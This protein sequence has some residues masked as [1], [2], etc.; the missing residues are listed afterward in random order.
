ML[1]Y[2]HRISKSW[3][4]RGCSQT[5]SGV[6][7]AILVVGQFPTREDR[8]LFVSLHVAGMFS[9]R[10]GLACSVPR[11]WWRSVNEGRAFGQNPPKQCIAL[12]DYFHVAVTMS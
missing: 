12:A 7:V 3:G 9:F 10:K 4:H 8:P 5:V 2:T 1:V 6:W 11:E